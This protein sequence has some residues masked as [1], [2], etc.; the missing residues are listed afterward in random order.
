MGHDAR[1]AAFNQLMKHLKMEM[2]GDPIYEERVKS[3]S[4]NLDL[5]TYGLLLQRTGGTGYSVLF[6][7][8]IRA[9]KSI[10]SSDDLTHVAAVAKK[11]RS[12]HQCKVVS[13]MIGTRDQKWIVDLAAKM[14]ILPRSM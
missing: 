3:P 1:N 8:A 9:M 14:R 12:G 6:T 10:V 13:T 2:K 4:C 7:R 5:E 11:R